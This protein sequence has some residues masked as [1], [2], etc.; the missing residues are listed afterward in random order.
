MLDTGTYCHSEHPGLIVP[1]S[2][3]AAEFR[4]R[5]GGACGIPV[6]IRGRRRALR[7]ESALKRALD[8]RRHPAAT[9]GAFESKGMASRCHPPPT[10]SP[11]VLRK[12][13]RVEP[14]A[15]LRL[16]LP[17]YPRHSTTELLAPGPNAGFLPGFLSTVLPA[18]DSNPY[19]LP[20]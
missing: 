5:C 11:A 18:H 14:P 3:A 20:L 10:S 19:C 13:A 7:V 16:Q 4:N 15:A 2:V 9:P 6:V 8:P 12:R 17:R 1:F